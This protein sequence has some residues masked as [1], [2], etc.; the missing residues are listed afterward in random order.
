MGN[1]TSK[2]SNFV[3]KQIDGD[4]TRKVYLVE[5]VDMFNGSAK[6]IDSNTFHNW[7]LAKNYIVDKFVDAPYR[8]NEICIDPIEKDLERDGWTILQFNNGNVLHGSI[9]YV[10]KLKYTLHFDTIDLGDIQCDDVNVVSISFKG[11]ISSQDRG[12]ERKGLLSYNSEEYLQDISNDKLIE[13]INFRLME[14][15]VP[16]YLIKTLQ[17]KLE[18]RTSFNTLLP[19]NNYSVSFANDT[20]EAY[21]NINSYFYIRVDFDYY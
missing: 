12:K 6:S 18:S 21:E 14:V 3:G 16:E 7:E 1:D 20:N 2:Y 11:N 10:T 19:N 9:K 4:S 5:V 8:D 17:A 15:G 13:D